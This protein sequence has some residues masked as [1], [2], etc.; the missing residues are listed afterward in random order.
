MEIINDELRLFIKDIT[1]FLQ[2]QSN[3]T[4]EKIAPMFQTAYKLYVKYDVENEQANSPDRTVDCGCNGFY[5][6]FGVHRPGCPHAFD[7]VTYE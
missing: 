3:Y 6:L 2:K 7:E 4:S 5:Q 1:L